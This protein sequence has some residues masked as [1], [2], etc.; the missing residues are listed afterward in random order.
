MPSPLTLLAQSNILQSPAPRSLPP[1][2]M[3]D[4][5]ATIDAWG[6][7]SA[8][9]STFPAANTDQEAR[10]P[11][12]EA[13]GRQEEDDDDAPLSSAIQR[14]K[15]AYLTGSAPAVQRTHS[16]TQQPFLKVRIT[17]LERNRKDLLIR[18]DANVSPPRRP[19]D[20]NTHRLGPGRP[21]FQI[22]E[23]TCTATCNG[24]T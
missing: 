24:P 7:P 6:S 15:D 20:G 9:L 1:P 19:C 18:F 13:N 3:A 4:P 21:T 5:L 16:S 12:S 8:S 11:H 14:A 10:T 23:P 2:I 22:F 17:G